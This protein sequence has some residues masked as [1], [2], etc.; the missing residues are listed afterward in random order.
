[1]FNKPSD[2]VKSIATV[3]VLAPAASPSESQ[4]IIADTN[5]ETG[6]KITE[7][8]LMELLRKKIDIITLIHSIHREEGKGRTN[9]IVKGLE[10]IEKVL[11]VMDKTEYKWFADKIRYNYEDSLALMNKR[12]GISDL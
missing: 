11:A 6:K 5:D 8:M 12:K 7:D 10:N 3:G 4:L 1:M 2:T 9:F